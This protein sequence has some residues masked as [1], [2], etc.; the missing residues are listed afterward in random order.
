MK[1]QSSRQSPD[2]SDFNRRDFLKGSSVA[3]LAALMGGT[4]L[5][6]PV[7]R[8][9]DAGRIGTQSGNTVKVGVV[10]CGIWGR[11]ILNTLS[12]LPSV[13]VIAFADPYRPMHRRAKE[14]APGAEA[15]TD[16]TQILKNPAIQGVVV[17]TPSHQHKDVVVAA[18]QAGKHVFCEAPLA[19]TI[20]DARAIAAAAKAAPFQNFQAG[21]GLRSDPQRAFLLDFIRAGAAGR[22]VKARAQ[23]HKKQS[24]RQAS[25]NAE[26][27][28]ALNWRLD[29]A[30]SPGLL[31]E[32]SIHALD[33]IAWYLGARPAAVTGFGSTVLWNDGREVPDSVEAVFEFPKGALVNCEVTLANSFDAEYEMIYGSDAAVMLRGNKAWMFK[34]VDAPLL[35]WEVY[36]RKD[37]FYKETGIALVANATKLAAQGDKPVEDAPFTNTPLFYALEAF[38]YNTDV[39]STAVKDFI[40]Q[41]G[42]DDKEALADAV[43]AASINNKSAAS[44]RDG[45]EATVMALKGNEAVMKK[46]RIE[47][48]ESLFEV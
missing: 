45:Y 40:D 37:T 44:W 38:A 31:G 4:P 5:I 33:N 15:L 12:R 1:P 27:E 17:A 34:E 20:D 25:P 16:H 36:A 23:S 6:A 42:D 2:S 11:E 35:G 48:P 22:T 46:S 39:V 43:K 19:H 29:T 14:A 32:I 3:T 7:V 30:T 41:F 8:G 13:E 24:W 9:A 47:I 26:R 21:L 28:K 10:G 18:L